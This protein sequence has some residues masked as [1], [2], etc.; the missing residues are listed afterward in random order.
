ML[1]QGIAYPIVA[2]GCKRALCQT[3]AYPAHACVRFARSIPVRLC[4]T[5]AGF[6]ND[7]VLVDNTPRAGLGHARVIL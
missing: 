4:E 6:A 7:F 1:V 5:D 2:R 3:V